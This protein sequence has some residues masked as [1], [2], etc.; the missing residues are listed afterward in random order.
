MTSPGGEAHA[1]RKRVREISKRHPR[2]SDD[3]AAASPRR[4]H[5]APGAA[6]SG[7]WLTTPAHLTTTRNLGAEAPASEITALR[8]AQG[9]AA[10]AAT[11]YWKRRRKSRTPRRER[12]GSLERALMLAWLFRASTQRRQLGVARRGRDRRRSNAVLVRQ[13]KI[14][15]VAEEQLHRFRVAVLARFKERGPAV[16]RPRPVD[17]GAAV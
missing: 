5:V 14:R 8:R 17:V 15:A 3:P 4:A 10:A 16:R 2:L 12:R 6:L 1:T 7:G 11:A 9:R 13:F